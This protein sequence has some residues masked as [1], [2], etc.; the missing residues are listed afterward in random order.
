M[1]MKVKEFIAKLNSFNMDAELIFED[2]KEPRFQPLE[3]RAGIAGTE[4]KLR[5]KF[6]EKADE[7]TE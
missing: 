3:T 5:I 6:V 4:K 2:S 7:T 1:T